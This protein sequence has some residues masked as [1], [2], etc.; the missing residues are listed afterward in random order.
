MSNERRQPKGKSTGGQFALSANSES[1]VDLGVI[2]A[3]L[4]YLYSDVG[5]QGSITIVPDVADTETTITD[6]MGNK[7]WYRDG[8][9]DRVDGPAVEHADGSL[10]FYDRGELIMKLHAVSASP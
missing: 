7:S 8:K 2:D 9:L 10:S 1:T 6:S 4:G 3:D 5:V